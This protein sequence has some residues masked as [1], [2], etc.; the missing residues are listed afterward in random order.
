MSKTHFIDLAKLLAQNPTAFTETGRKLIA[1]FCASQ[2]PAFDKARF[3]K[4][5]TPTTKP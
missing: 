2:N 1:D 4:A 3:L 5:A